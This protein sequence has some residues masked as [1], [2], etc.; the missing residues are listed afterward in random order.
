M[1]KYLHRAVSAVMALVPAITGNLSSQADT[2]AARALPP[3]STPRPVP[4]R[5]SEAAERETRDYQMIT[6][7]DRVT[8]HTRV[9][10]VPF[11]KSRRSPDRASVSFAVSIT[12]QGRQLTMPPDSVEF[13]FTAFAP[14]RSGWALAHPGPLKLTVDDSVQAEIQSSSYQRLAV[15]LTA[16][17]RREMIAYRVAIPQLMALAA[18]PEG[19]LK[20]GRFTI[21]LDEYGREGLRALAARLVP[22]HP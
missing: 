20:V 2:E 16:R 12:Y 13:I 17:G 14:A 19:K 21:K 3:V 7:Y 6:V 10:V 11:Q 9:T 1:S 4:R 18:A 15:A 5:S 22:A 8:N